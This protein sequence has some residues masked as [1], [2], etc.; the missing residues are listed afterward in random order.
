MSVN[1]YKKWYQEKLKEN[2]DYDYDEENTPE[3][4]SH[5]C[6]VCGKYEFEDEGLSDI[7]S[8]CGWED[9]PVMEEDPDY[10]GGANELCLNDLEA[11]YQ[12]FITEDPNI[13]GNV[14]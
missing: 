14:A 5:K 4:I 1:D 12:C 3:L 8:F 10:S 2:P 7:C 11:Q 9:D 6:P 13:I